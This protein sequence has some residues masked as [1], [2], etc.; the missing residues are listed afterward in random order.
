MEGYPC[1]WYILCKIRRKEIFYDFEQN[2]TESE[3]ELC[4]NDEH[5]TIKMYKP[6][7]KYQIEEEQM[8]ECMVK[9]AK[10]FGCTTVYRWT[11]GKMYKV[12][13]TDIYFMF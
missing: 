12:E 5:I 3:T 11:N 7:L 6:L 1:Q 13:R 8:K 10:N 9:W 2:K 4:T